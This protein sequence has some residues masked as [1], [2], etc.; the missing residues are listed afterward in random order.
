MTE[1]GVCGTRMT[2]STEW[3]K[4]YKKNRNYIGVIQLG[5]SD[6]NLNIS[7]HFCHNTS[8]KIITLILFFCHLYNFV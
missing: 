3:Q 2:D 1:G 8:M 5:M 6:Y 7:W 4:D